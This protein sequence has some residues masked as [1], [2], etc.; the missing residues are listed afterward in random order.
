MQRLER[1]AETI[2]NAIIADYIATGEPVG[3]RTLSKK[4]QIGVSA[5]TVRNV[6]SD[7]TDA[8]YITQPHVS[9]GRVPT[10]QGYRHYVDSLLANRLLVYEEDDQ[11]IIESLLKVAGM[12]MRDVLRQSSSVLAVLSRQAGVVTATPRA[13]QTFKTIEFIKVAADRILVVLQSTSGFLQNKLILDEEDIDQETLERYSRMLGDMLKDLDL[14]QARKR[15]EE[16]LAK[17]RNKVDAILSKTLQLSRVMLSQGVEWEIFIEGRSN[18]LDEPEFS[19][20]EQVKGLLATLEDKSKLLRILNKT[21]SGRGIE[22]MIG[23]EHG[24]NEIASCAIV[25]YPIRAENQVLA[26]IS[27][28][29]PK[30]MN[31]GKVV[32]LVITTGKVLTRF[33]KTAVEIPV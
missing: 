8:G 17:E 10:D 30:R 7:L 11:H 9:A 5:A 12:E 27:V 19:E 21:L 24:L 6:M 28:I 31:Y 16:E 3:S 29:G 25:G 26:S 33:L 4:E 23:A 13:K 2:L 1:R 20:I 14:E 15:I 32:P 22:I 18:I